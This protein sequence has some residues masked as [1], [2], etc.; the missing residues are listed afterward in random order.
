MER[1]GLMVQLSRA[2]YFSQRHI[3]RNIGQ[4][5]LER[6]V[7]KLEQKAQYRSR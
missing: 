6:K 1:V 2:D 4:V 3:S 7:V 5:I